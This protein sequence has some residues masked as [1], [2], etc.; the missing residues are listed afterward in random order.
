M[1]SNNLMA[2]LKHSPPFSHLPGAELTRLAARCRLQRFAPGESI[3]AVGE[4]ADSLWL[5]KTGLV[6]VCT[7]DHR[8][9]L[10]VAFQGPGE[11]LDNVGMLR[12]YRHA[13]EASAVVPVE[14]AV[15][16][17]DAYDSLVERH[18]SAAVEVSR[19]LAARLLECRR[20]RAMLN[21]PGRQRLA[22]LLMWLRE[23]LGD[24]I[25]FTRGMLAEF[26]GFSREATI[27]LLSP[28]EKAG[29]IATRRGRVQ[30]KAPKRIAAAASKPS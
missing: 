13:D 30:I 1:D 29:W 3:F 2:L 12:H 4:R 24:E 26:A 8:A 21:C 15:I 23:R 5:I 6:R 9:P 17:A 20:M 11:L 14:A 18:P 19:L 28:M 10:T 25:P 16:P 22:G 27:R 7:V